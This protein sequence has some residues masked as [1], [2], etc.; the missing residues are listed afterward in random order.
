MASQP[1]AQIAYQ[2][3]FFPRHQ[4]FRDGKNAG[5]AA[6]RNFLRAM[7]RAGG[8]AVPSDPRKRQLRGN[9]VRRIIRCV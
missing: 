1:A 5:S 6:C 9:R 7:K 8:R 3:L 2:K 4:L